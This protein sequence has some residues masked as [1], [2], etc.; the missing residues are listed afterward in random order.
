M[1][2]EK[3][4]LQNTLSSALE[5]DGNS[6]FEVQNKPNKIQNSTY[7]KTTNLVQPSSKLTTQFKTQ[8][9]TRSTKFNS[10]KLQLNK[11]Q[12]SSLPHA[13]SIHLT[14]LNVHWRDAG[15][16]NLKNE[17]PAQTESLDHK[18]QTQNGT[19]QTN[20]NS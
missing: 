2:T 11:T 8:T 12:H 18:C 19:K 7:L 20:V 5:S 17:M 14:Q 13:G 1:S 16:I 15:R 4:E 9:P 6:K 10:A 3:D